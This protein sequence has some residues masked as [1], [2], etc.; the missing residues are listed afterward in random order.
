MLSLGHFHWNN[1]NVG[2]KKLDVLG[3]RDF[4]TMIE[5]VHR[6][7]IHGNSANLPTLRGK[8]K[9]SANESDLTLGTP[10]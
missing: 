3:G 10:I 9:S 6:P 7:L 5:I 2:M 4:Y 8:Q 1:A